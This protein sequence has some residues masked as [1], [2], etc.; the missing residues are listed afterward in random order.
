M[1]AADQIID[2]DIY[3]AVQIASL[4]KC[5]KETAEERIRSGD[6]PGI[7]FGKSWVIPRQ[8]LLQC[9]NE[10]ALSEAAQRK[11]ELQGSRAAALKKGKASTKA[12]AAPPPMLPTSQGHRKRGQRREPPQLPSLPIPA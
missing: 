7:K 8:A 5:D 12:E 11:A 4:L 2:S 3:T 10:M 6:L 9:L 1:E